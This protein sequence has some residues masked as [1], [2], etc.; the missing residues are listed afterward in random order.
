M[1]FNIFHR[2]NRM[3]VP[4]SLLLKDDR[5]INGTYLPYMGKWRVPYY[6]F[7]NFNKRAKRCKYCYRWGDYPIKEAC[8]NKRYDLIEWSPIIVTVCI[9][10]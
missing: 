7:G 6:C 3:V 5:I 2:D 1:K 8:K 10:L 4:G 9:K